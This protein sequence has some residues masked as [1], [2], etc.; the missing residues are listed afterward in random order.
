M[1]SPRYISVKAGTRLTFSNDDQ[2]EHTVTSGTP[3]ARGD[4]FD[5]RLSGK[6]TT[7][8]VDLTTPGVYRYFCDR[9]QYMRGEIRVN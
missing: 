3:E 6:G 5:V 2:I 7:A 9:H 4:R 8:A 1:V